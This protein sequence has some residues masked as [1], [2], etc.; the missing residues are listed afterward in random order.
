MNHINPHKQIKQ[1]ASLLL[2]CHIESTSCS[3]QVTWTSRYLTPTA[4]KIMEKDL[5]L[6][7]FCGSWAWT[8]TRMIKRGS[9]FNQ[10]LPDLTK[11]GSIV[12]TM[13]SFASGQIC[14]HFFFLRY[15]YSIDSRIRNGS[16]N[17]HACLAFP[18]LNFILTLFVK[19]APKN[20]KKYLTL[21]FNLGIS[22]VEL[23]R[24]VL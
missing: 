12:V 16:S 4:W 5:W 23:C 20:Q 11:S 15:R 10:Q 18:N 14:F 19:H 8:K 13:K 17:V 9:C 24:G 22:M 2:P 21:I 1:I 7:F 6:C 3:A